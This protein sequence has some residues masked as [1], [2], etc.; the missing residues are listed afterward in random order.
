M[1]PPAG[2]AMAAITVMLWI[3]WSDSIRARGGSR[4]I[5]L[6]RIVAYLA[7]AAVLV[8]NAIH[9]PALFGAG[10]RTL[11]VAAVIVAIFGAI[12]FGR[13]LLVSR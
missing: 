3:L 4:V 8:Y 5:Y 12:Y 1:I 10:G 13:K 2:M 7:M 11:V 6:V 9:H